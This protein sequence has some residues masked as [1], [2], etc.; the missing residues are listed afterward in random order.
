MRGKTIANGSHELVGTTF[1]PSIT[2][3]GAEELES[4][5]LRLLTPRLGF[6]FY[7]LEVDGLRVVLLEVDAAFRHPAKFAGA[8]YIRIGSYKEPLNDCAEFE[9]T[10]WRKLA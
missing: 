2:R 4:W 1:N 5:L 3:I 8:E 7:R 6:R 10:L 9:R